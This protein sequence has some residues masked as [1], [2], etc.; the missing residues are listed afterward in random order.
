MAAKREAYLRDKNNR[1]R[2]LKSA[3]DYQVK[4]KPSEL[5]KAL[6]D[7]EVFGEYDA[8]NEKLAQNRKRE[9]EAARFNLDYHEQKKRE[10]LLSNL[11]EQERA[12]EYIDR[13]K[14]E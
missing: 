5:P 10:E 1:Q 9:I 12:A 3:L 7:S 2:D 11:R 14:E 8:K 13:V 6:P 4:T